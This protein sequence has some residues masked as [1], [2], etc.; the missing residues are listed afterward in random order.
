MTQRTP[1]LFRSLLI[2]IALSICLR[3]SFAQETPDSHRKY[4]M[5]AVWLTT[6]YGLDWPHRPATDRAGE[7]RQKR[8]LIHLLDQ[9][10]EIGTNTIF[11]QVRSKGR[12]IYPSKVEPLSGEFVPTTS[13]YKLTYDPLE[14]AINE[15][16]KRGMAV[17]A[18]LAVT[19]I[20]NDKQLRQMPA[21]SYPHR[22]RRELK[23]YKNYWY[24]DPA[25]ASTTTHMRKVVS[26]I[27]ERYPV[28]G[29]HLDY[30]RYPDR[31]KQFPDA[32]AYK[33]K[34]G[35]ISIDD[36]R[37][38]N[39][40]RLVGE[41]YREIKKHRADAMLSASVI[42]TYNNVP[43]LRESGWTAYNDVWQDPAAWCREGVIDFVVPMMYTKGD[44]F[45]PFVG[46]WLKVLNVPL[47]VGIAPYMVHEREGNWEV[48][49]IKEQMDYLDRL[50]DVAGVAL[51]RA[52]HSVSSGLGTKKPIM[53][54]WKRSAALPINGGV[55]MDW[56]D[57]Q[58]LEMQGTDAGLKVSWQGGQH[59]RL[60][61]LYLS[62]DGEVPNGTDAPFLTTTDKE[63]VIPWSQIKSDALIGIKVSEYDLVTQSET[64]PFAG[65]LYY[66]K[67]L[68]DDAT[69]TDDI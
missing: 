48:A 37:R 41:I 53:D 12:V 69:D 50:P 27:L 15:C 14:F 5:K 31:A 62:I 68:P 60:Y 13:S 40:T 55:R 34:G 24:M 18:W 52:E 42:G 61:A 45:Y 1:L 3:A 35:K 56:M 28:A 67:K 26:E 10:Q 44:R 30:I 4:Q 6:N 29:I 59:P 57:E 2:V 63:V 66:N 19:P 16:H 22:H 23:R 46:E 36:W 47:V 11:L 7:E 58:S 54:R 38:D 64:L 43:G 39:I 20:G 65:G 9:L 33:A 51:F 32:K 17:H 25:N 49:E 21:G 8:D